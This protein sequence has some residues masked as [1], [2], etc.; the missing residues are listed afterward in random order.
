MVQLQQSGED[1]AMAYDGG[2]AFPI[3]TTA[4]PYAPGMSL[5]DWFAGQALSAILSRSDIVGTEAGLHHVRI[6]VSELA[7]AYADAMLALRKEPE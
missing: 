6:A 1:I 2:P 5:R 3:E 4:T 7:F